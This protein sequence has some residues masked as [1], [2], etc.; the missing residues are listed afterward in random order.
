MVV[1]VV[2]GSVVTAVLCRAIDL[3]LLKE[4]RIVELGWK[5]IELRREMLPWLV[6]VEELGW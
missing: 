2:V 5:I 6:L 3:R 4:P 1:V